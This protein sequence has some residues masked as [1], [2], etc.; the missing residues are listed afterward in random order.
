MGDAATKAVMPR[1]A[2][3]ACRDPSHGFQDSRWPSHDSSHGRRYQIQC[4]SESG[5]S[6]RTRLRIEVRDVKSPKAGESE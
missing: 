5:P 3:N 1:S 4:G 2:Y 6:L